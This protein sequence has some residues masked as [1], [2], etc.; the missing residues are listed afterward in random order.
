MTEDVS[1]RTVLVDVMLMPCCDFCWGSWYV[2]I[3]ERVSE[4]V[5]MSIHQFIESASRILT[6]LG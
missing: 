1:T 4:N 6:F 3:A 2:F 5:R